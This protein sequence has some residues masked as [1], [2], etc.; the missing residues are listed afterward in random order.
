MAKYGDGGRCYDNRG[1]GGKDDGR[2][3]RVRK[4]PQIEIRE[5]NQRAHRQRDGQGGEHH[6]ATRGAH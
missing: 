5:Q 3:A 2:D 6:S 4:G 1:R